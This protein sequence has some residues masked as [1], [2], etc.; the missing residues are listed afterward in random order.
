MIMY[1]KKRRSALILY[2][3][4]KRIISPRISYISINSINLSSTFFHS[5]GPT[6]H[7]FD[8]KIERLR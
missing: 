6:A 2:I 5:Q 1:I 7:T 4:E 8:I 3:I